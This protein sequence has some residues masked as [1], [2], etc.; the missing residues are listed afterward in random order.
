MQLRSTRA[1]RY[2]GYLVSRNG[3]SPDPEKV[4]AVRDLAVPKTKS[5]LKSFLGLTSYYRRFV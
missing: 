3:L 5:Q 1:I 2:L 4:R